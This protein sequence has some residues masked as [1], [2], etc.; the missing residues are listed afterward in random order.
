MPRN[1]SDR[2]KKIAIFFLKKGVKKPDGG[3]VRDSDVAFPHGAPHFCPEP[4]PNP[5]YDGFA[6]NPRPM[7]SRW[8]SSGAPYH[9]RAQC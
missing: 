3:A 6:T 4:G 7:G 9:G 8:A 5:R 1:R 2:N